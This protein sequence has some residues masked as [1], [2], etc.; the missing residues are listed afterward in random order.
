MNPFILLCITLFP[1]CSFSISFSPDIT[2]IKKSKQKNQ[3]YSFIYLYFLFCGHYIVFKSHS[4]QCSGDPAVLR[5][6]P[7][8]PAY[9]LC[10]LLS[11]SLNSSL[12]FSCVFSVFALGQTHCAKGLLSARQVLIPG[13]FSFNLI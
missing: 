9:K 2:H 12:S 13:T 4:W 5:M 1:S 11:F 3:I 6:E 8:P 10:D 7:R